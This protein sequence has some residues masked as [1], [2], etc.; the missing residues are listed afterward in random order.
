MLVLQLLQCLLQCLLHCLLRLLRLLLL[1]L[2]L[3]CLAQRAAKPRL[4]RLLL[5]PLLLHVVLM[6]PP[7][8]LGMLAAVAALAVSVARMLTQVRGLKERGSTEA[9]AQSWR[10]RA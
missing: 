5:L 10:C 2:L 6:W 3:Q 9:G 7:G 1:L 4:L 8:Q